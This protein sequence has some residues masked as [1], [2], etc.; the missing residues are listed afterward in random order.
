MHRRGGRPRRHRA[1]PGHTPKKNATVPTAHTVS[2]RFG[3]A[4]V[5]GLIAVKRASGSTVKAQVS[6]LASGKKRLRATF[7]TK[8]ASGKYTVGWRV[9]ADGGDTEKGAFRFTV[10]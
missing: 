1:G 5:T 2:V 3:E 6:G 10:P 4:L 9:K 7:A 8:L